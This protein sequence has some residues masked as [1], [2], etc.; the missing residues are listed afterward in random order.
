[1][2]ENTAGN[3][4]ARCATLEQEKYEGLDK[5]RECVQMAEE[6]TLQKDEVHTVYTLYLSPELD[7]ELKNMYIRYCTFI[8]IVV[9][10]P[11][12]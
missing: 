11:I 12:R 7:F 1:M 10:S 8:C 9:K 3:L 5:V 2:W 4:K 6:A